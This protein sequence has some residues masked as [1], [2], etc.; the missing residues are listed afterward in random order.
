M[1][2][3]KTI[4]YTRVGLVPLLKYRLSCFQCGGALIIYKTCFQL[5]NYI[6]LNL[7]THFSFNLNQ[8]LI[9]EMYLS[10]NSC[11]YYNLNFEIVVTLCFGIVSIRIQYFDKI[12]FSYFIHSNLS[13]R[14]F[15]CVMSMNKMTYRRFL[16]KIT[17]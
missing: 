11:A 17:A 13:F 3:L 12:L 7:F 16:F 5:Q 10:I 8:R 6:W 2:Q 15:Q 1:L 14:N 9:R 4:R